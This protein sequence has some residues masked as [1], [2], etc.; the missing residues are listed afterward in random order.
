[1]PTVLLAF[2]YSAFRLLLDDLID[3]RH[4]EAELRLEL[5]VLRH[6]L[7]VL[8]AKSSGRVGGLLIASCSSLCR[9]MGCVTST[10]PPA[11]AAWAAT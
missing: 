10:R 3:R 7:S 6:Q 11:I 8:G 5:L 4:P 2:L 1:L 9:Y